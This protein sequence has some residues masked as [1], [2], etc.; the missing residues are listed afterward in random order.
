[1]SNIITREDAL[2]EKAVN[3]PEGDL[4]R[5]LIQIAPEL[6]EKDENNFSFA[7][8]EYI[9][10]AMG[11]RIIQLESTYIA[12]HNVYYVVELYLKGFYRQEHYMDYEE[13]LS[14]IKAGK[15]KQ[16]IEESHKIWI[17][18]INRLKKVV[19][20]GKRKIP[21]NNM[22]YEDT[23][24]L[25]KE[26]ERDIS[27]C[28]QY[29]TTSVDLTNFYFG[30]YYGICGPVEITKQTG[31]I[32]LEE[33]IY[34]LYDEISIMANLNPWAIESF[35][36][37]YKRNVSI[38]SRFNLFEKVILNY[39]FALPYAEEPERLRVSKVDADLLMT[40]MRLGTLSAKELVDQLIHRLGLEGYKKEYMER[41][42]L[43]IQKRIDIFAK[44]GYFGELFIISP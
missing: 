13:F 31:F 8:L 16:V 12:L 21:K 43:Y 2:R 30:K 11:E 14:L 22:A 27:L 38:G 32:A 41:Y 29:P 15:S 18:H 24:K 44:D 36:R 26:L 40:E 35:I 1:M 7:A 17:L 34:S 33:F 25:L 4:I 28:E 39:L 23:F 42:A 37:Y 9:K 20:K 19:S 3:A 6:S 10:D 5:T